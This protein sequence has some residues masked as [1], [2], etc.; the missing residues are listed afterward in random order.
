MTHLSQN[1]HSRAA[2]VVLLILGA[3]RPGSSAVETPYAGFPSSP[4]RLQQDGDHRSYLLLAPTNAMGQGTPVGESLVHEQDGRP[5]IRTGNPLCDALY[6]LAISEACSNSVP[7]IHDDAYGKGTAVPIEAFQTGKLWTYV[8]TRDL[9]YS[10]DLAL[11]GFDPGRG[12]SSL[13]FKS[14]G[15]K[16][17]VTS[18]NGPQAVQDTGSGG[19][20]PVSTDRVVW[21]LGAAALLDHLEG[22]EHA[23][24]LKRAYPILCGTIE[25]DRKVVFDPEDGLYR[26]EQSFLDWREQ[27]YPGWTKENTLPIALSK[28]LSVNVLDYNLLKTASRWSGQLGFPERQS[29]Y[30][31]WAVALK[32]AINKRFFDRKSGL[33]VT[34]LLSD[35]GTPGIA[36][37][38]YDLLG[39][40]LAILLGVADGDRAASLLH[41]YP[42]GPFGPSVVWPQERSVP[43]YHNQAIWPFVTAYWIKAARKVGNAAA[44]DEGIASLM[45]LAADQHSNME[46][47]D[48]FTGGIKVM[49]GPRKGP[50][51]NSTRQLWSVA[52]YLSMVQDVVFGQEVSPEGIRFRP[53]VTSAMRDG[54]F[55]GSDLLELED[56]PYLGTRNRVRVHL[57]HGNLP[58]GGVCMIGRRKLNGKSVG[59][60]F[61]ATAKLQPGNVWDIFLET[62]VPGKSVPPPRA[63]DLSDERSIF[64]PAGPRW[65]EPGVSVDA[66][67]VTLHYSHEDPAAVTFTIFRDGLP[68]ATGVRETSWI[69]HSREAA[70]VHSYVVEAVDARTGTVSHPTESRSSRSREQELVLPASGMSNTGGNLV[71]GHH[72]E[73]WG[74]PGHELLSGSFTVPRSG[75]YFICAEVLQ[76]LRADQHRHHLR[77]EKT[78]CASGRYR[79]GCGL[80][81]CR[82][83]A[84]R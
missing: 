13:L 20:Y 7:S 59:E 16:P 80:R 61:V 62:P 15:P 24:F 18:V 52:G 46:N 38:R 29:R 71:G 45:R 72:F 70:T 75:L 21:A 76:R 78:R 55:K 50:V 67:K 69:D 33:Y 35:D 53:F 82:D 43:I 3:A 48:F 79:R 84:V 65:E 51:I 1:F 6:A 4:V 30:E 83:A 39:E 73:N 77:C 5:R 64:G 81:L 10:L 14:S 9:S 63:V 31:A 17:S 2:L 56:L 23:E 40:S 27:T 68:V 49:D 8:W 58:A 26:G 42:T 12:V 36:T 66:G 32:E 37:Q 60:D 11:A 19:S 41:N 34:Y 28:A 47:C 25:Q 22:R 74:M 44:V 54:L 57:P